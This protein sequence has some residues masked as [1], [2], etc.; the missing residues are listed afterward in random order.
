MHVQHTYI[1]T[2]IC[3]HIYTQFTHKH[4]T[5][6]NKK[7][8]KIICTSLVAWAIKIPHL[9]K[10]PSWAT[11]KVWSRRASW[12]WISLERIPEINLASPHLPLHSV[13]QPPG[14][15]FHS[16]RLGRLSPAATWPQHSPSPVHITLPSIPPLHAGSSL[17][18]R[19]MC[20]STSDYRKKYFL[21]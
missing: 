12:K 13:L 1:Y 10:N 11:Q 20:I 16:V 5:W 14:E 2:C 4:F 3:I 6:R 7:T 18:S 19:T 17:E 15:I 21:D 8:I 9:R